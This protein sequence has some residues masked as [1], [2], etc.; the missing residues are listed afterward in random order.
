MKSPTL[1]LS[2][3][4]AVFT[5]VSCDMLFPLTDEVVEMAE[6]DFFVSADGGQVE[7]SFTPLVAWSASCTAGYVYLE[8]SSG[9][10]SSEEVVMTIFVEENITQEQRIA[11][12][13]M[14]FGLTSVDVIVTQ[15]AYTYPENPE[16]PE[17]PEDPG[18]SE[19]PDDPDDSESQYDSDTEDVESGKD[20]DVK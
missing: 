16:D 13:Q 17:D 2:V 5:M 18:N 9:S 8:P 15:E 1:F 14:N 10:A 7:V 11:V 20:I 4:S 19:N 3:I 6:T 12:V